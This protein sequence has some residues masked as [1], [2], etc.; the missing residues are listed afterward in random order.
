M[1]HDN[2][3]KQTANTQTFL[4]SIES[5]IRE[6][7]L[8]LQENNADLCNKINEIFG[9]E[10][11]NELGEIEKAPQPNCAVDAINARMAELFD[12]IDKAMYEIKRLSRV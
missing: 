4:S 5:R 10:P 1:P 3:L 8:R 2:Q 9:A 12:Q 7:S 6:A 11:A